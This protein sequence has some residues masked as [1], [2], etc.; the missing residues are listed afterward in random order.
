MMTGGNQHPTSSLG[1]YQPLDHLER[2][3]VVE[4]QHALRLFDDNRNT[5][6]TPE[7]EGSTHLSK[8]REAAR[9]FPNP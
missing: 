5:R 1:G 8:E 4:H 3:D 7:I 2:R 6:L 9:T